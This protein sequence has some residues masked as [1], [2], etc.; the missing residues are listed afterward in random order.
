MVYENAA[1]DYKTFTVESG[2][3][4][5]QEKNA[6]ALNAIDP[7]LKPFQAKG[8]KLI[9]YHGWNDP[10]IPALN[11]VN[12]YDSVVAKMGQ[13][14]VDSFVRLYM[15]PGMQHCDDGPGATSFG[16]VGQLVADDPQRSVDGALEQWVEKGS[17]PATIIA[18][19]YDGDDRQ[20]PKMTR[21]LCTYPQS[22]KYKGS[23][24]SNDAANFTCETGK[25]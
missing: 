3:N 1:W 8:G 17:A 22:A 5:A 10:A 9:L 15:V 6:N 4:A 14:D 12:Y 13:S 2:L 20:H 23:G 18:R 11:T 25:K 24:D 16:Q 21:P 7:D 19:K